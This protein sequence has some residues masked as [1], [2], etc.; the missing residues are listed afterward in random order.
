MLY[1]KIV[2]IIVLSR[3]TMK[4][5][6]DYYKHC[7]LCPRRCGADRT[8]GETGVCHCTSQ[9]RAARAALHMW[10]EP[11]ISGREGSGAIFFT[12]CGLGCVYCP[13]A[14]ISGG[15]SGKPITIERLADIMLELQDKGA[16][17]INLV[18]PD[19]Y[20][21]SIREAV[22]TARR[23]GLH[24]P[25]LCNCSGY[26][27]EETFEIM[28]PFTDIW[29]PD[30]KYYDS[31]LSARFSAAPDYFETAIRALEKM[32]E[33]AGDPVFDA[34]GMMQRG[35]IVRHLVLPGCYHDSIRLIDKLHRRFGDHIYISIMNQYTP[36]A[37]LPAKFGDI[38]RKLTTY[39]YNKVT[40][41]AL[42]I[43]VENVFIQEGPTADDSFIPAFDYEG[44]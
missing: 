23:K 14:E 40:D 4:S 34:R 3:G 12:G 42:S 24:L 41:Y 35:V 15:Q 7:M 36:M 38:N 10:E 26:M 28:R 27:C 18:T 25:V 20:A 2:H 1:G 13:N 8:A 33:A 19:H 11:C 17:N 43:G 32:V 37:N 22:Q 29:L 39:E 21:P 5:I 6:N 31:A 16:N 9:L 30:M 44:V